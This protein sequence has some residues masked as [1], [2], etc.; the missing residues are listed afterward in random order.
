MLV[1]QER[2]AVTKAFWLTEFAGGS[3]LLYC[4]DSIDRGFFADG[5]RADFEGRQQIDTR[6]D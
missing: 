6:C 2:L 1:H 3:S 4:E 5:L